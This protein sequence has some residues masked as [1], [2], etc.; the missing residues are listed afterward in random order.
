MCVLVGGLHAELDDFAHW[1]PDADPTCRAGLLDPCFSAAG[2]LRADLIQRRSWINSGRLLPPAA[3][4]DQLLTA[5]PI[6]DPANLRGVSSAR[7][8]TDAASPSNGIPP[9]VFS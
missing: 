4:P 7:M 3:S 8:E 9:T 2:I 6:C 1:A 5:A